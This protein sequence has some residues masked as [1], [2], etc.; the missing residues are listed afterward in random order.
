MRRVLPWSSLSRSFFF[1]ECGG[2]W[3][4][5]LCDV[6]CLGHATHLHRLRLDGLSVP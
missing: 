3:L 6:T 4:M 1:G 5:W 2:V